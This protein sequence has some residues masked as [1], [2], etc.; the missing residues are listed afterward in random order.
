[1][2]MR[3]TF[4]TTFA[5]IESRADRAPVPYPLDRSTI[6][7][8][9]RH[10]QMHN[11]PIPHP[12]QQQLLQRLFRLYWQFRLNQVLQRLSGERLLTRWSFGGAF[13]LLIGGGGLV[14]FLEFLVG[15]GWF[16]GRFGRGVGWLDQ[17]FYAV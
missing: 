3:Q 1:M 5:Q 17:N 9:T 14:G 15:L 16:D 12:L 2:R 11:I 13:W 8:I 4:L 10:P 7:P 6:T